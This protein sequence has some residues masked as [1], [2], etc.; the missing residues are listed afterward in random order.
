MSNP[1]KIAYLKRHEID[2]AKWSLCIENAQ[3]S[4]I[5]ANHWYLDRS[6]ENWHALVLGNYEYVMPLPVRKKWGISY[7]FQPPFSQ[8]LGIFPE[9]SAP[10]ATTFYDALQNKFR[11]CEVQLN[12]CNPVVHKNNTSFL[13][14]DNF[15]LPLFAGYSTLYAEYST[16]TKR[17]IS[18]AN[19]WGLQFISGIQPDDYLNFNRE[20]LNYKISADVLKKL[21]QLIA[22]GQFGGAGEIYGVYSPQNELC[23]A[24]YFFR[25]KNRLIYL[26][27]VSSDQGKELGAMFVL[28]DKI[29]SMNAGK[30]LILD[31]EG[32]M[33]P[34]V[35]RFYA[36]FGAAPE[37]YFQLR[38]NRLPAIFRMFKK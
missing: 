33:L 18:K 12:A 38:F 4:R 30:G 21:K 2:E 28:V 14:R 16:N 29:V 9:P 34:G 3:N 20:N 15:L 37:T 10:I 1:G 22:F 32:S 5:Y 36:G 19:H 24:V 27:S 26:N 8:Q 17:N 7:V 13:P 6:T 11:F 23:A 31:F 25:W 35:A